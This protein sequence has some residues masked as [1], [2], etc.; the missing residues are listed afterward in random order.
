MQVRWGTRRFYQPLF[1]G[2]VLIA[3][4]DFLPYRRHLDS[5]YYPPDSLASLRRIGE[6]IAADPEDFRVLPA[7]RYSN[8]ADLV[9]IWHGK[10]LAWDFRS[11]SAP[12]RTRELFDLVFDRMHN[13]AT[14]CEAAVLAGFANVKYVLDNPSSGADPA[15]CPKFRLV[16]RAADV[17]LYENL[18][19]R[20]FVQA[21]PTACVLVGG[22]GEPGI[23]LAV[24][25][26]ERNVGLARIDDDASR[27]PAG[28][29]VI[30]DRE[31]IAARRAPAGA[32]SLDD[33]LA[34]FR[35]TARFGASPD[36]SWT[37]PYPELIRVRSRAKDDSF[38]VI[39]ESFHPWWKATLDG[40]PVERFA[41][42]YAFLGLFVPAGDHAIE[43]R[44][45][46]PWTFAFW[47]AVSVV[48]LL[49]C[50]AALVVQ[51]PVVGRSGSGPGFWRGGRRAVA[52]RRTE[53]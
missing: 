45:R 10:R 28:S 20:P 46:R 9:Y 42:Q 36:L 25:L 40:R 1:L 47:G 51:G 53:P 6:R 50:L 43:L 24:A 37:R 7:E 52:G 22:A 30:A 15:S 49:G 18:E 32:I 4:L 14:E 39:S 16:Q 13:G 34:L 27:I 41:G 23:A 44:Y 38:V 19:Y 8:Q 48:S 11:Y 12:R 31:S 29:T 21:Y 5:F 3:I 35:E 33:A 2:I 17:R 26:G